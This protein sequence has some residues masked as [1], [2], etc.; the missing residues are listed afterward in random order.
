M[1]VVI[2][3]DEPLLQQR[4]ARFTR[5]ILG[6]QLQHLAQFLSLAEAE[7]FLAQNE[8]DLLLLDL[9]LHGQNGFALLKSQLAKAF[10]T[11]VISAYGEKALE[12]FEYGVLD[13][14]AK[15]LEEGRL[16]KALTRLTDN[17]LRSHYGCRYL[18]VKKLSAIELVEVANIAYVQADGHYSEIHLID[19]DEVFLHSKSIERIQALLPEQFERIHRSYIANINKVQRLLVESG[20]RYFAELYKGIQLPVSRSKFQV[21]KAHFAEK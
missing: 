11:I 1:R 10:H 21:L 18:S 16:A 17:S 5:N 15:P 12:A 20:G 3:E 19:G 8:V 6:E 13:F 7:D 2:V 14:I 4:I 9:N